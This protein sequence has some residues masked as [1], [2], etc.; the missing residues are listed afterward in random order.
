MRLAKRNVK[1]LSAEEKK[2]ISD[3]YA[4]VDRTD[5]IELLDEYNA[6][7]AEGI[8]GNAETLE[9]LLDDA[10]TVKD[11]ILDFLRGAKGD[12]D[13]QRSAA[14]RRLFFKYKRLFDKFAQQNAQNIAA[15]R[16]PTATVD[17]EKKTPHGEAPEANGVTRTNNEKMQVSGK[18]YAIKYPNFSESDISGNLNNYS[19]TI[20]QKD[21]E[22]LWS[23]GGKGIDEFTS[24]EIE[25]TQKWAYKFYRELGIKSPF[26]RAWF[27]D[28]RAYENKKIVPVEHSKAAYKAGKA[29]NRDTGKVI[30]WG[31]QLNGEVKIKYGSNSEVYSFLSDIEGIVENSILLDSVVSQKKSKRKMQNTCFMH[32]FYSIVEWNN[33]HI[34]VKLLVEEAL[35]KK[36]ETSFTRGYELQEI[37]KVADLHLGVHANKGSLTQQSTTKYSIADLFSFVK[38]FDKKIKLKS[39]NPV[40][41]AMLN[42]DGT[43]KMFYHGTNAVFMAF[44]RKKIGSNTDDGVYG[45]GFYFS[46]NRSQAEQYG[47]SK[48]YF[49]NLKN[50]LVLSDYHSI[51]ELA[52]V[53]DMSESNFS[54]SGGVIH[55]LNSYINS[56]TS[57]LQYAGY[58][59]VIVDY[60]TS[61]EVVVFDSTQIKSATD[62][63]GTFDGSNPNI[64]FALP[65]MD[66]SVDIYTEEEYNNFGWARD[67]DAISVKELDDLYS[68][69]QEKGTLRR[70]KQS[71]SGEAIVEVNNKPRTT[72]DVDNV[73]VFV[74]GTKNFPEITRVLRVSLFSETDMEKVRKYIYAREKN[75]PD[76]RAGAFDGNA[77]WED[78]LV[79]EY[80]RRDWAD[81]QKYWAQ[82]RQRSV[83]GEG[84]G[85]SG[86]YR[87][88]DFGSGATEK[89]NGN[90]LVVFQ[91]LM[92][93]TP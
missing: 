43:P 37:Q 62:N 23:I 13:A 1:N 59:G 3:R 33:S 49:L 9:R 45:K 6:H 81:Y 88:R 25:K 60:G 50:P 10:P 80:T 77:L 58:D 21:M 46:S 42:A 15:E 91:S 26:F 20:S 4:E 51:R 8:L 28:W 84:A 57:H 41:P 86:A 34:L 32:S 30:S 90:V 52:D 75:H 12:T 92:T 79:Y 31:E 36:L 55:P 93:D 24:S 85:D 53:L 7:Y 16:L 44:D 61:D 69:I 11:R 71:A 27:G 17:A 48:E 14:A 56:F 82:I 47:S 64:R 35:D 39:T 29:L 83:R 89:T 5:E 66:G 65:D 54:M 68:K 74:K 67:A 2:A 38:Q 76:A 63:I 73:F 78:G 70:F 87:N 19:E 22:A 40:N 72:L 18:R